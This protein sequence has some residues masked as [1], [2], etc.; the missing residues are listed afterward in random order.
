[1]TRNPT[2]Y[3]RAVRVNGTNATIVSSS[4]GML[5]A[6]TSS[7]ADRGLPERVDVQVNSPGQP[8]PD[9]DGDGL[10]D[11]AEVIAG[12]DP[13]RWVNL[14]ADRHHQSGVLSFADGPRTAGTRPSP[15]AS[16]RL[17][18][19]PKLKPPSGEGWR[20]SASTLVP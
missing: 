8:A 13:A 11:W 3:S 2:S 9:T 19:V 6:F 12:T 18:S 17:Q 20:N 15:Y 10:P 4:R 14:P 1:M 7:T 16:E 5:S